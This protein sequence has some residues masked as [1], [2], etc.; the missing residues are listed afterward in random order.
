MA[1]GDGFSDSTSLAAALDAQ[2]GNV[3]YTYIDAAVAQIAAIS[4]NG[5]T[6]TES[7]YVFPLAGLGLNAGAA[8]GSVDVPAVDRTEV[9]DLVVQAPAGPPGFRLRRSV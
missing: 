7:Q 6:P 5:G 1:T 9:N 2:L 8:A 3:N 4:A